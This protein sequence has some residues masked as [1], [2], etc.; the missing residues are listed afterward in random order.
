[1]MRAIRWHGRGDVRLDLVPDALP[2]GPGEVRVRVEWCGICG[3]DREEWR[4]GPQ[5]I[6]V[7]QP[8]PLTGTKA[9][10][11]LGHE[12]SATVVDVGRGVANLRAGKLVALD[13][14]ITCGRCW[15]C[16]RH[17]VTL[18]PELASIG[19][20][21]DGGLTESMTVAARMVFPVPAGVDAETAA[22]AEPLAVAIRALRKGRLARGETV[23][24]Q[25]AGMVGIAALR[26][27]M[28]LG[29]AAVTVADPFPRRREGAMR[30]GAAA[31]VDPSLSTFVD[32]V[33]RLH[34]GRGPDLVLEAAGTRRA[35]EQ[36]AVAARRGGRTVFVGLPAEP[37]SLDF[38]G[39]VLA[40]REL[41]G[42]LSHIW[43][44][45]FAAAVD[46][47]GEGVIRAEQVVGARVSLERTVDL[48]FDSI[49]DAELDGIKVLVSPW[50]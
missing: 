28:V 40:E 37:A 23:L 7:E 22:L 42:S 26:A 21:T 19:L 32:E 27:A 12:V 45:D 38:L 25:G 39:L 2:P 41:I 18:C 16:R 46:M 6:P 10:I 35:A 48:G 3:T 30:L 24:V 1:M 8:H 34:E 11:V 4:A 49:A 47:L 13:G 44:E 17:E 5:W 33:L 20:H 14:L 9:P 36:A 29:A 15:W 50:I 43:D 31:V